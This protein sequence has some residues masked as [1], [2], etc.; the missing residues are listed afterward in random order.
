M[1]RTEGEHRMAELGSEQVNL[2]ISLLIRFPQVSAVHYEPADRSLRFVYLLKGVQ[3]SELYRFVDKVK[4]HLQAFHSIAPAAAVEPQLAAV[5]HEEVDGFWVLQIRRDVASLTYEELN[6]INEVVQ[7]CLGE[8]VICDGVE[9]VADE[10]FDEDFT[11]AALLSSGRGF[12]DERLSG[13]R[14]K[15][16]VLVF[17]TSVKS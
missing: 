12:G 10:Y 11:I 17:S 5:Q 7:E 13:Y 2:L 1:E 3:R 4:E 6:L 15:G 8:A 16:R 9:D 14:E